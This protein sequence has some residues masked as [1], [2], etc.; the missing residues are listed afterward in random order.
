MKR[1]FFYYQSLL[2]S[3]ALVFAALSIW[4]KEYLFGLF[5]IQFFIGCIQYPIATIRFLF[6]DELDTLLEIYWGVSSLYLLVLVLMVTNVLGFE[7]GHYYLYL[8]WPLAVFYWYITYCD[9][10]GK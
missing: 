5:L 2:M 7:I 4:D 10:K 6:D 1:T 8:A 9:Y 3:I